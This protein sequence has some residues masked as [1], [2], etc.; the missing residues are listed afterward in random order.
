MLHDKSITGMEM[1]PQ[2]NRLEGVYRPRRGRR[3]TEF[4]LW[5]PGH[6]LLEV[7]IYSH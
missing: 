6:E 7:S 5:L 1:K 4:V 3:L 2:E